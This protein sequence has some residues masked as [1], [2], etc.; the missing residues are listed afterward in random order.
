V[1]PRIARPGANPQGLGCQC[2]PGRR[3]DKFLHNAARCPPRSIFTLENRSFGSCGRRSPALAAVILFP[4]YNKKVTNT[5]RPENGRSLIAINFAHLEQTESSL[6]GGMIGTMQDDISPNLAPDSSVKASSVGHR[7]KLEESLPTSAKFHRMF[8]MFCQ[9]HQ[10]DA[11]RQRSLQR[12]GRGG[13]EPAAGAT[14]VRAPALRN[15][16]P[17][18]QAKDDGAIHHFIAGRARDIGV[19]EKLEAANSIL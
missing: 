2:R 6:E 1:Q 13:P 11:D 5:Q 15:R 10:A 17:C 4:K 8:L 7:G 16:E 18:W 19:S 12:C 3:V 9:T 14:D